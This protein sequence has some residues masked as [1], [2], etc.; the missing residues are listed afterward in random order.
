MVY[1]KHGVCTR[2]VSAILVYSQHTTRYPPRRY[3]GGFPM[4][5]AAK[6]TS[7]W[8]EQK[9]EEGYQPVTVWIPGR[10]KALMVKLAFEQHHDLGV[11]IA[12]ACQAYALAKGAKPSTVVDMRRMEALIDRK[13]ADALAHQHP[14]PTAPP[15]E[16]PPPIPAGM[17]RCRKGHRYPASKKECPQCVMQRKKA[18]RQRQAAARRGALAP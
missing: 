16:P 12:E 3:K 2:H 13:I 6:R 18:H 17:K 14:A 4:S 8:R 7:S 1:V 9:R 11:E 10:I 15:A 5:E